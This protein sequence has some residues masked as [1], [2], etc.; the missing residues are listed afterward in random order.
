ME[1]SCLKLD[2]IGFAFQSLA[3]SKK[4]FLAEGTYLAF[5]ENIINHR[6]CITS[7]D[8]PIPGSFMTKRRRVAAPWSGKRST[9]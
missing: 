7:V 2:S 3:I 5:Y 4:Q 9:V 8:F 1:K 6:V